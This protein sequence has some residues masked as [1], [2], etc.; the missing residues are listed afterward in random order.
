MMEVEGMLEDLMPD[1]DILEGVKV[2]S[3]VFNIKPL[4]YDQNDMII[5]LF[6]DISVVH[7]HLACAAGTMSNLCKVMNPQQLMLIMQCSIHPL[8]HLN[9]SPSLF[10]PQIH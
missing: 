10:D 6:D 4:T 1:E 9:M 5:S 7:E 8:M 2:T 3:D